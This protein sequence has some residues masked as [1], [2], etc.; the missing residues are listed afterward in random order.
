MMHGP[1]AGLTFWVA[2]IL[3]PSL[4]AALAA[5][6]ELAAVLIAVTVYPWSESG[7]AAAAS[8]I[9]ERWRDMRSAGPPFIARQAMVGGLIGMPVFLVAAAGAF[10]WR[11]IGVAPALFAAACI[12]GGLLLTI[13]CV[14]LHRSG[15]DTP[16]NPVREMIWFM[17]FGMIFAVVIA[18]RFVRGPVRVTVSEEDA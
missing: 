11:R 12:Q 16:L 2:V 15:L 18:Q 5:L 6:V 17:G 13:A 9:P 3:A 10:R 4:I 14:E 7:W 1:S 8:I